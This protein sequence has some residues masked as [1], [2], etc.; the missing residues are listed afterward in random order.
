MRKALAGQDSGCSR[1][2]ARMGGDRN[3]AALLLPAV[4]ALALIAAA[5]ASNPAGQALAQSA[6]KPL[7]MPRHIGDRLAQCWSPPNSEPPELIEVKVRLRFSRD[8]ALMGEPRVAYFQAPAP[9]GEAV[10]ASIL[11]AVKACTPLAFA[12][13]LGGGI[14]GRMVAIRYRLLPAPGR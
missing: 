5:I 12:P 7:T 8:G 10:A 9:L 13:A 2:R 14:A 11:N 4:P 6:S 3:R 1:Q